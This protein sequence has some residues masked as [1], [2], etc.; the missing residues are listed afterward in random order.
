MLSDVDL[1]AKFAGGS[2][3]LTVSG[4]EG[5]NLR[6]G[7]AFVVNSNGDG[8]FSL[9]RQE[10]PTQVEIGTISGIGTDFEVVLVISPADP[11]TA[12]DFIL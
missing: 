4:S 8:T 7:S 12:S 10:G 6:S 5:I 9:A 3:G 1:P 11:I 2:I